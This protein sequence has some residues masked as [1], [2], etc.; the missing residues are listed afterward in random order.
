MAPNYND[1][2]P[3]RFMHRLRFDEDLRGDC[4][5][6][7]AKLFESVS[8]VRGALVVS[9]DGFEIAAKTGDIRSISVGELS[10]IT[11]TI[12]AS[13]EELLARVDC[14]RLKTTIVEG[15]H[16]TVI[17][18][19]VNA[20]CPVALATVV[21]LEHQ[22][23]GRALHYVKDCAHELGER[24]RRPE[25]SEETWEPVALAVADLR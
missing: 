5:K 12:S 21:R 10:A 22:T 2:Q 11:T 14:G 18:V 9:A 19:S 17:L 1:P 8:D 4:R 13:V 16:G 6:I 23:L 25:V 20:I 15:E 3:R 7:V 24:L